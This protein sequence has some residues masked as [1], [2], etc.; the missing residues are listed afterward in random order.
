MQ[1]VLFYEGLI[2]YKACPVEYCRTDEVNMTLHDL[3]RIG[4][5]CGGCAESYSLLTVN[6]LT[7]FIAWLNLT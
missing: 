4:V 5:L 2:L 1:I 3:G 7:V 6:I